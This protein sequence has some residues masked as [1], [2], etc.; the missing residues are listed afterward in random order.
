MALIQDKYGAAAA[1][2]VVDEGPTQGPAVSCDNASR[3]EV[4]AKPNSDASASQ[5]EAAATSG[6][7]PAPAY[8]RPELTSGGDSA[9]SIR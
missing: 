6:P 1:A 2:M 3:Y 7:D 4:A 8:M 9:K 5:L